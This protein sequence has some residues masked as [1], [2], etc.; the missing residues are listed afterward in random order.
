MGAE[1]SVERP[2]GNWN[3]LTRFSSVVLLLSG[4]GLKAP[5]QRS[6]AL[7]VRLGRIFQLS[8]AKTATSSVE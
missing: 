7:I 8:C 5:S 1:G 2:I 3:P 6:P 4:V